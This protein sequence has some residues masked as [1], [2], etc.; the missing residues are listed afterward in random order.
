MA[1]RLEKGEVV[2]LLLLMLKYILQSLETRKNSIKFR[3]T[4]S[5]QRGGKRNE[6]V[7]VFLDICCDSTKFT[8]I[9]CV[10]IK[11]KCDKVQSCEAQDIY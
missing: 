10:E 11:A 6:L 5:F 1:C 9:K 2:Y 7:V 3:H 8:V 4:A